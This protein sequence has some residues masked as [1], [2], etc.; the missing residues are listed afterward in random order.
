MEYTVSKKANKKIAKD[1]EIIISEIRKKYP[2]IISIIL[3]G[4]FS[5]GE[6][7][8]KIEGNKVYPYND[9][10]I[11]IISKNKIS[12][13]ISDKLSIDISK[14]LGYRG[15]DNFYPFKKEEQKIK[16]NFYIDL[17]WD[18][19]K[20][21]RNLLP[22]IRNYELKKHSKIIYGN[23]VRKIIPEYSL[24]D[25]PL[26]EG[27]KLLLDR[28]SQMVEYY[29]EKGNYEQECL[30]YFI[31]QCYA[32]CCTSLLLLSGK[33]QIGYEKSMKILKETY[34]KDFPELYK[35]IPNLHHKIEY[36]VNW[37]VD[38]KKPIIKNLKEEWFI[39]KNNLIEVTKYFFS[40]FL[41]KNI[42]S[43]E[44]L[45]KNILRMDKEFYIPYIN[46]ILKNKIGFKSEIISRVLIPFVKV[47]LIKKYKDRL[48]QIERKKIGFVWNSPDLIIFGSLPFLIDSIKQEEVN[49]NELE[50]CKNLL[51]KVY[52][53]KGKYWE[54]ISTEYANAYILFFLQKI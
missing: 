5:R 47:T 21:L 8:V 23:D 46:S 4:G 13:D 3:S 24:K 1:M 36:F 9:Y 49:Q 11:Q 48:R 20:D 28:M 19:L 31:Q 15:I 52:P 26:S 50:K 44:D 54:E 43:T 42:C 34:E 37:K 38:P 7:P 17:K 29:S 16:D 35:K 27:A 6:G 32:A 25:M 30:S 10:D 18:S 12:K 53:V 41:K 2:E 45:S 39:A 51:K 14:K 33:Y 22:R 40:K